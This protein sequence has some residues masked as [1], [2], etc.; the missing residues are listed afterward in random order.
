MKNKKHIFIPLFVLI[1][2]IVVSLIVS[3]IS[4]KAF[5]KNM[6]YSTKTIEFLYDG[7]SDGKDPDGNEF[8]A[9]DLLTE[10]VINKGIKDAGMENRYTYDTIKSYIMV[11][12]IVPNNVVSEITA[13]TSLVKS[14]TTTTTI[15]SSN[16]HP[17]RFNIILYR[18]FDKKISKNDLNKLVDSI[19][20]NYCD[21]FY[22]TY[23]KSF[24]STS[25]SD[26]YSMDNY[27]YIYQV[28]VYENRLTALANF[29]NSLFAN[30]NTFTYNGKTFN[31]ISLKANQLI[32]DDVKVI[33]NSIVFNALSKDVTRLKDYYNY[34]IAMLNF[35]KTKYTTDLN[36]I[37]TQ[38]DNY[39]KDS[40][41]YIG[42]GENIVKVESNSSETYNALLAKKISTSEKIAEIN[43]NITDYTNILADIDA[44]VATQ[45]EYDRVETNLTKLGKSV[46]ELDKQFVEII[47]SYND[48][49]IA[50]NAV[51]VETT[52]YKNVTSIFSLTFIIEAFKLTFPIVGLTM[53]GICV[54][55]LIREIRKNKKK[56]VVIEETVTA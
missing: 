16:Y 55:Y 49:N 27:D 34:K 39:E 35:D 15:T 38:I 23:K 10:E 36:N 48:K 42:S 40:T 28:E 33:R 30:N 6:D 22:S 19:T 8:N 21:L 25:Y 26:I 47:N 56:E 11:K 37:T 31:D 3:I 32:K 53:V 54:Y 41:V 5:N 13:Y 18:D 1:G 50:N 45:A 20:T 12:N 7:A 51:K 52:E 17:T 46:D 43:T 29:A 24:D 44:A 4:F 9:S 14:G 2:A